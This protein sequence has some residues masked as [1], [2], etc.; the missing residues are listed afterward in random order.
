MQTMFKNCV[1]EHLKMM[2]AVMPAGPI[3]STALEIAAALEQSTAPAL[4][5]PST[6]YAPPYAYV[7]YIYNK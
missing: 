4:P 6:A 5:N 2:E 1:S 7:N 3:T